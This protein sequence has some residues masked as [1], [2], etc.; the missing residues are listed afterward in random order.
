MG[1]W[2]QK[3]WKQKVYTFNYNTY[4]NWSIKSGGKLSEADTQLGLELF[5]ESF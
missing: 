5:Y 2:N 3:I 1:P 4:Y